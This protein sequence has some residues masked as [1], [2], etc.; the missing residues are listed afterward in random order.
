MQVTDRPLVDTHFLSL[1]DTW[2]LSAEIQPT[3]APHPLHKTVRQGKS[4]P[5][6]WRYQRYGAQQIQFSNFKIRT[7]GTNKLK[8]LGQRARQTAEILRSVTRQ[9]ERS[10]QGDGN[11]ESQTEWWGQIPLSLPHCKFRVL[12]PNVYHSRWPD[13]NDC[14]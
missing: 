12:R 11:A 13:R 9:I 5:L 6:G 10:K 14:D 7:V 1:K 4:N 2:T 3:A 8:L